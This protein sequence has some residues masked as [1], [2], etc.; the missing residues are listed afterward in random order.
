MQLG[1]YSAN[2]NAPPPHVPRVPGD[3]GGAVLSAG[4]LLISPQCIEGAT[5]QDQA[6]DSTPSMIAWMSV[7]PVPGPAGTVMAPSCISSAGAN[8]GVPQ[9]MER[10]V[11]SDGQIR[12]ICPYSWKKMTFPRDLSQLN[13]RLNGTVPVACPQRERFSEFHIG[14]IGTAGYTHWK[15]P[16]SVGF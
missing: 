4:L 5:G 1:T 6:I 3:P 12:D 2:A 8:Q 7:M 13:R 9:P 16:R 11:A 14:L 15:S 10:E